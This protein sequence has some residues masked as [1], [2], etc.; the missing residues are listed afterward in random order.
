[1]QEAEQIENFMN[2]GSP[3]L[4]FQWRNIRHKPPR[5]EPK[6]PLSSRK[7]F[8]T[9][10]RSSYHSSQHMYFHTAILL[11]WLIFP[12]GFAIWYVDSWKAE[13]KRCI[14][15][16]NGLHLDWLESLWGCTRWSDIWDHQN[17]VALFQ[18]PLHFYEINGFCDV[19]FHVLW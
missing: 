18:Y 7:N 8:S 6:K 12:Y 10:N 4:W 14:I 19:S 17:R 2:V 13:Q 9:S 16:D 11:L 5:I 15:L 1:M 3:N